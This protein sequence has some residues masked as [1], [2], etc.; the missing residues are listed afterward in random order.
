MDDSH[1]FCDSY[2]FSV[3]HVSVFQSIMSSVFKEFVKT[4]CGGSQEQQYNKTPKEVY[5]VKFLFRNIT[6]IRIILS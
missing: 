6:H 5:I 4:A 3:T 2:Y 1:I